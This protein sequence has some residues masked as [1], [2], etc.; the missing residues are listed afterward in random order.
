MATAPERRNI[1]V[2]VVNSIATFV[3]MLGIAFLTGGLFYLGLITVSALMNAPSA[4]AVWS[5]STAAT[6]GSRR[7]M[8]TVD[9]PR[10]DEDQRGEPTVLRAA[11]HGFASIAFIGSANAAGFTDEAAIG[12]SISRRILSRISSSALTIRLSGVWS[13]LA[14][15]P[16]KNCV[17]KSRLRGWLGFCN[18]LEGAEPYRT[19][20]RSPSN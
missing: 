8:M 12:P 7:L 5:S 17:P 14:F 6:A 1:E 15:F 10:F 16:F 4:F 11:A 2:A 3:V 20:P 18:G 13:I 9:C 19:F